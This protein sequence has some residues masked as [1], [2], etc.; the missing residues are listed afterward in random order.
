M[1][2]RRRRGW[3]VLGSCDVIDQCILSMIHVLSD[4]KNGNA[5]ILGELRRSVEELHRKACV[6]CC[7]QVCSLSLERIEL[8]GM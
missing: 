1:F 6:K 8:L 5:S 7:L 4:V 3:R 2:L